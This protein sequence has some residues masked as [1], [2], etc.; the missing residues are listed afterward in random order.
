[1]TGGASLP[2]A[3]FER[4][5]AALCRVLWASAVALPL[6]S[7][8][9][10]HYSLLHDLASALPVLAFAW[11]AGRPSFGPRQRSI[12]CAL[13]LLTVAA[14][15][16]HISG[17]TIEAHFAFFVV[18]V[19]LTLYEDWWPLLVAVAYV[20]VHHGVL[21]MVDPD[22]VWGAH[23]HD[24]WLWAG[25]H[26]AFVAGAGAAAL[27]AWR[28]NE[29]VRAQMR[30][31]Q[32]Q[33]A[34]AAL[35]DSLTGL[36]NRR[37]LLPDLDAAIA[38]ATPAAPA[39]FAIFDLDGFKT[40]K[41][42]FGHL[43]GDALL[44][45]L[46]RTLDDAV[47]GRARAYRLG[48]GEFCVIAPGADESTIPACLDALAVEGPG[49]AVTACYGEVA[50]PREAVTSSDALRVADRR[51]Y[52]RR[53]GARPSAGAQSKDVL[54]R[55]LSERDATVDPRHARLAALAVEA[56]AAL[57]CSPEEIEQIGHAAELHDIGKLALPG[58]ILAKAG[59]LTDE[60]WAFIRRHT[61]VGERILAGAP[62]LATAARIVR[63]THER[64]DGGG[65]PDGL[66]GPEI[67]LGARI[68]AVC[69]A[70]DAM[71]NDRPYRR[72]MSIGEATAELRG[73]AGTQF[74]P[75]VVEAV[76]ASAPPR[77]AQL[78]A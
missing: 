8:A 9:V 36:G 56:A 13:G 64:W 59:A 45:R 28:F 43:A 39:T 49:F 16:V 53:L 17:G 44:E 15:G 30:D 58:S 35:T 67:P 31:V 76:L 11:M 57:G 78:V 62:A 77:V 41:D 75:D 46:G 51:M 37:R 60:E 42:L 25:V 4:R 14:L 24:P 27:I 55:A 34:E 12:A 69:D 71:L 54:L 19:L 33:L 6:F 66:T 38:A 21:G 7:L 74:D 26:A 5:H 61:L 63:S 29:A 20:F 70:L 3:E 48:G 65:Y 32:A 72:A 10:A 73:G 1:M 40:Y 50:L 23:R 68:I 18:V 52:Q 47:A 2:V 22:A